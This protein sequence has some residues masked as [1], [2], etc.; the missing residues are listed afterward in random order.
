MGSEA[1]AETGT[2]RVC[3]A[4]ASSAPS[5]TT[6]ST[7]SSANEATSSSLNARQRMLGSMP[8]TSTMSRPNPSGLATENR[9]V[10]QTRRSVRPSDISTTGRVTWK[11]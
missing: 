3:G 7:F 4:S 9:V 8:C 1:A 6:S 11:S 5:S 2:G 10:G